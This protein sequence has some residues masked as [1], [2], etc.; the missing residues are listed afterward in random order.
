MRSAKTGILGRIEPCT[1]RS[2]V[3]ARTAGE[4]M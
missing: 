1:A 3:Q 2:G 4:G